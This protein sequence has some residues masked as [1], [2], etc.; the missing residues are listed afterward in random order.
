M[1]TSQ[2]SQSSPRILTSWI[3]TRPAV[4]VQR[5]SQVQSKMLL[6]KLPTAN[7]QLTFLDQFGPF[8]TIVDNFTQLQ[9][10]WDNWDIFHHP[11]FIYIIYYPLYIVHCPFS[12]PI[13]HYPLTSLQYPLFIYPLS[14]FFYPLSIKHYSLSN[15]NYLLS[16][17]HNRFSAFHFPSSMFN[18]ILS[19]IILSSNS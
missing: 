13:F 7:W 15:F 3:L 12:W 2:K 11:F 18:F 8:Q 4:R 19:S 16:K 14:I 17:F 1:V 5:L 9:T 10:I 6:S